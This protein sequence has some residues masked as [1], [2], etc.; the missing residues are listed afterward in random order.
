MIDVPIYLNIAKTERL[1][2]IWKKNP[3]NGRKVGVKQRKRRIKAGFL[4]SHSLARNLLASRAQ[5]T[6]HD[7][8]TAGGKTNISLVP[9]A[10]SFL[11]RKFYRLSCKNNEFF[12]HC[13]NISHHAIPQL[14]RPSEADE[15]RVAKE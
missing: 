10:V 7:Y 12:S 5:G 13:A 15:K 8:G 3:P 6:I 11:R 9:P 14:V 1:S 2:S 4:L